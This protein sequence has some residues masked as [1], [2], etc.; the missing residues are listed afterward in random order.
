LGSCDF[1][2]FIREI[3]CTKFEL[4]SSTPNFGR[5]GTRLTTTRRLSFHETY[6]LCKPPGCE[7]QPLFLLSPKSGNEDIA[8]GV[9]DNAK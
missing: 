6:G 9:D 2:V 7:A 3:C 8:A 1:L 4:I 5:C